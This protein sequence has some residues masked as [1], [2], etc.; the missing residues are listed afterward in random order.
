MAPFLD[1][2][3]HQTVVVIR[4]VKSVMID[5]LLNSPNGKPQLEKPGAI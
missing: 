5:A 4:S 3:W 2:S 1:F